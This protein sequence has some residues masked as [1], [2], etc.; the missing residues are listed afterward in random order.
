[1]N[2]AEKID[3]EVQEL[4]GVRPGEV[5]DCV[6]F[7]EGGDAWKSASDRDLRK[8]Q[9]PAMSRVWDNPTDDEVWNEL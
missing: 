6:G 3:E 1:M 7:L 4:P 2:I 8:A 9:A 5:H